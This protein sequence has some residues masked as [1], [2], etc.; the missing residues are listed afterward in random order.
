MTSTHDTPTFAGW[1][2]GADLRLRAELDQFG[3]GQ[4]FESE[5]D[6]RVHERDM[7]WRTFEACGAGVSAE[8]SLEHD[9]A[10]VDAAVGFAARTGS[11]LA[12][13][14][15][16]DLLGA[17]EQINLPGT[18]TQHPN[19]RRR[20]AGD[21]RRLLDGPLAEARIATLCSE[22]PRER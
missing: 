8:P 16:E 22:R 13:V 3:P 15:V 5:S 19:W 1:W 7:I 20:L 14:P 6:A 12:I 9:R 4:S 21:A 17:Q 11:T 10:A 18:T 2:R